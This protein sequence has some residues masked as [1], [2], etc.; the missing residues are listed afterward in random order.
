MTGLPSIKEFAK[1]TGI[2]LRRVIKGALLR[3]APEFKTAKVRREL[4]LKQKSICPC[5][6]C[7]GNALM[8]SGKETHVD[9]KWTTDKAANAVLDGT[10][11]LIRAYKKL[12]AHKNLQAVHAAC[13]LRRNRRLS[14]K[15]SAMAK[16]ES[17][18]QKGPKAKQGLKAETLKVN[19]NRQ[20]VIQT[21]LAKKKPASGWPK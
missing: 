9:H 16:R 19:G 3:L 15:S 7:P 14:E 2:P 18:S 4:L 12:W 5:R 10:M 17:S 20:K 8:D 6:G 21:S 1:K 11:D 13:N